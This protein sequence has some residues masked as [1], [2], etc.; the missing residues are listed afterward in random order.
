MYTQ[1]LFL[2]F[3]ISFIVGTSAWFNCIA[4]CNC[5]VFTLFF[6]Y[7]FLHIG[8][9]MPPNACVLVWFIPLYIYICILLRQNVYR[10]PS[11]AID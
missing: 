7:Y 10:T 6:I 1:Q 4:S 11:G 9:P 5:D 2:Y 3:G 8:A